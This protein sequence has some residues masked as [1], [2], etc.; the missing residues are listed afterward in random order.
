MSDKVTYN[1]IVVSKNII[2][3]IIDVGPGHDFWNLGVW[4]TCV[5][6]VRI[7]VQWPL[8]GAALGGSRLTQRAPV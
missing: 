5:R 6:N 7:L 3:S 8:T 1:K 2:E 4:R